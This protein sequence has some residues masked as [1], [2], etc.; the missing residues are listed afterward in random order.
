MAAR[1]MLAQFDARVIESL[2]SVKVPTLVMMGS[3][4]QAYLASTDYMAGKLPNATKVVIEDAG[5]G[6]NIH[7]PEAFDRAVRDFLR[8]SG[9]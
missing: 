9:L 4:D 6:A 5:H 8:G 7:Q 2:E 3:R 1:G